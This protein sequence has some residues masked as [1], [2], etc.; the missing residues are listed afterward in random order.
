MHRSVAKSKK[1]ASRMRAAE[2][3]RTGVV[4]SGRRMIQLEVY[5]CCCPVRAPHIR[6]VWIAHSDPRCGQAKLIPLADGKRLGRPV[7]NML[8]GN[9][10]VAK[11]HAGVVATRLIDHP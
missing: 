7:G 8:H 11:K 1:S 10:A 5:M 9:R 3:F 6:A 4:V 2:R